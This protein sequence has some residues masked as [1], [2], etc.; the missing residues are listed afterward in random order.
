MTVVNDLVF[1]TLFNGQ[2]IALN[3]SSGAIVYRGSVPDSTNAGIAVAGN[4]II[5]PAGGPKSS[6]S[7]KATPQVV[8]YR[9]G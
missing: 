5:V 3:R 7:A 6:I 8:A 4:T 1:T 2:L 9:L